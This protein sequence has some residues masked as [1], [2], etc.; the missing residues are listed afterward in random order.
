MTD[1][2]NRIFFVGRDIFVFLPRRRYY[3]IIA[4]LASTAI[5]IFRLRKTHRSS[6]DLA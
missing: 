4:E 2:E 5:S 6:T 1:T 3:G